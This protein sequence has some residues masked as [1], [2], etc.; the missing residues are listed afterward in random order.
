MITLEL[1]WSVWLR[2]MWRTKRANLLVR[3][4]LWSS[5]TWK[6]RPNLEIRFSFGIWLISVRLLISLLRAK[7]NRFLWFTSGTN[8]N[9]NKFSWFRLTSKE[10]FFSVPSNLRVTLSL[11]KMLSF[12][13]RFSR[14]FFRVSKRLMRKSSRIF[15]TKF[16]SIWFIRK[17]S[18]KETSCFKRSLWLRPFLVWLFF[19]KVI[20]IL[21]CLK[22]TK[23]LFKSWKFRFLIFGKF[24]W[25]LMTKLTGSFPS[26]L[27][28]ESSR[29]SM[30][31]F[32]ISVGKKSLKKSRSF[33]F[34]LWKRTINLRKDLVFSLSAIYQKGFINWLNFWT[35]MERN[36]S[37]FGKSSKGL[38]FQRTFW[39]S[40][41]IRSKETQWTCWSLLLTKASEFWVNL[42]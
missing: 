18:K 5:L 23:K 30:T 32:I 22:I 39:T 33:L 34:R 16:Y 40:K 12:S 36:L 3:S 21:S 4:I 7:S 25:F 6:S 10:M 17:M 24:C 42:L 29:F 26:R 28:R 31:F 35:L 27:K 15:F 9:C 13:S 38:F 11:K 2:L 19:L 1:Q 14:R 37:N 41:T 20:S 8:S